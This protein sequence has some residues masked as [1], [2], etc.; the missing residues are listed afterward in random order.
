MKKKKLN[1]QYFKF[2]YKPDKVIVDKYP[3]NL[4]ELGFIKTLFP[5]KN[6]S[7]TRHP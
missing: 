1:E 6:Y 2:D 3:L 4:I 7:C 5:N